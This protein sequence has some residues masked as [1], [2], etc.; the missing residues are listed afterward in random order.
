MN[1]SKKH[2]KQTS[3]KRMRIWLHRNST[4][5]YMETTREFCGKKFYQ[6][7]TGRKKLYE[8]RL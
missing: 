1:K 7:G 6:I 5:F 3:T 2:L 4:I 8:T